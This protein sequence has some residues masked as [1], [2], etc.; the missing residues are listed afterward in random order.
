M[1]TF[2]S[3]QNHSLDGGLYATCALASPSKARPEVREKVLTEMPSG[4]RKNFLELASAIRASR[5]DLVA[6]LDELILDGLLVKTS[7]GFVTL[8]ARRS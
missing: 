6:A 1:Q 4:F 5:D 2:L 8:Y 3:F 7:D